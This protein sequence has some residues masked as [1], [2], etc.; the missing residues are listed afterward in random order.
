MSI[1]IKGGINYAL[2]K[3]HY[4]CDDYVVLRDP[5]TGIALINGIPFTNVPTYYISGMMAYLADPNVVDPEKGWCLYAHGQAAAPVW[6]APFLAA[7]GIPWPA[8]VPAFEA[9]RTLFLATQDCWVHFEGPVRVSQFIP[10]GVLATG[11][12]FSWLRR[13]FMIWVE[14]A[15]AVNGTLY[16][17][18]EG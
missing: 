4:D 15:G 9:K 5:T 14:R 1:D 2:L 3:R 11:P 8:E 16:V 6:L 7:L 18:I 17:W 12:Y 13:W 10:A